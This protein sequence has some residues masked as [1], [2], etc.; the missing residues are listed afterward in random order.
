MHGQEDAPIIRTIIALAH[1]LGMSV[2]AEGVETEQQRRLLLA[3]G[4]ESLQG[5]LLHG[6][7]DVG[8]ARA[9]LD[10]QRGDAAGHE[11]ADVG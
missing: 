3:L 6:P 11:F 4:C 9:L 10:A 7:L 1:N 5:F 8:Q 2:V